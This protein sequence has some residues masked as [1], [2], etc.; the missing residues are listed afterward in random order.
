MQSLE[1]LAGLTMWAVPVIVLGAIIL[2]Q[3]IRILREYE[4]GAICHRNLAIGEGRG[5]LRGGD[6]RPKRFPSPPG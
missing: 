2:S 5:V 1:A 4:R 6:S 3:M